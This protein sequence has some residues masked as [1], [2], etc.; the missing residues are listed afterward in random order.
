MTR[1]FTFERATKNTLRFK[2]ESAPDGDIIGYIYIQ[3]S[4]F[5]GKQPQAIRV[6]VEEVT[7][8]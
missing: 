7:E 6:T 4:A 1:T 8:A 3:K 5:N 2:E